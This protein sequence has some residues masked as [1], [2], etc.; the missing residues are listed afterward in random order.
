[1]PHSMHPC[2]CLYTPAGATAAAGCAFYNGLPGELDHCSP[3]Q[4]P[5]NR[6]GTRL[7]MLNTLSD[8][9][10][11]ATWT[12][13][14]PAHTNIHSTGTFELSNPRLCSSL[15]Q[16]PLALTQLQRNVHGCAYLAVLHLCTHRS[17]S[18]LQDPHRHTD[19]KRHLF[20]TEKQGPPAGLHSKVITSAR[21]DS[22]HSSGP[23]QCCYSICTHPHPIS[24]H[25]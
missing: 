25:P 10:L 13:Y 19:R 2:G 24:P 8:R 5:P 4:L 20:V 23:S 7:N 1:M 14:S 11:R 9:D 17:P 21:Q 22:T 3:N 15:S 16:G 12:L 6:C 18:A